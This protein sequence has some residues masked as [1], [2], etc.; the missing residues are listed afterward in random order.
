MRTLFLLLDKEFRQIF[1]DP[2]MPRLI[3]L[4]PVFQLLVIPLAAN[5]EIKNIQIAVVDHD[6]SSF[7]AELTR[8]ITASGYFVLTAFGDSYNEA[9]KL[10]E[11]DRA[12]LILEIPAGFENDLRR[13]QQSALFLAVNAINGTKANVGGAYVARII[14]EF[15]QKIQLDGFNPPQGM[16]RVAPRN[17]YNPHQEYAHFMVPGFLVMMV[18]MI[19]AYLT[20][21]NIVKEKEI[22][23]IEQINVTPIPKSIFI[24]GKLIPFWIIG[25]VVFTLGL[26]L[27]ARLVYGIIPE[28]SVLLLYGFLS[29]YLMVI[30]GIG[31]LISTYSN[32]QQQ[33]MSLA[34]F[35]MMI[36]LLMSGLFTSIESMP[37]WAQVMAWLNP[38]TYF[39]DVIR[40]VVLRG[41]GVS[42]IAFHL[43]ATAGFALFYNT[44]AIVN[45][46]K[47]T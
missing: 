39:V 5:F 8:R 3:F 7:S 38:L 45:Y 2:I 22:G 15:N 34:F 25:N 17:W 36:F 13:E 35:V 24:L 32:T 26:F 11:S 41:S 29:V 47:T 28:G 43:V 1:R 9:F 30:L 31:L 42:D 23:T 21:L 18:T 46:R 14:G 37:R 19:A 40:M 10:I 12:D 16:V 44:W 27:V 4:L 6:R 20:A 33:A